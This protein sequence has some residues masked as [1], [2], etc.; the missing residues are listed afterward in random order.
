MDDTLARLKKESR[1]IIIF[2]AGVTGEAV[3]NVCTE[4]GIPVAAFCDNNRDKTTCK[5]SDKEILYAPS[6]KERYPDAVF[7]IAVIDIQ[8]IVKQLHGLGFDVYYPVS[9]L[10]R[11]YDVFRYEYS[12]PADF[13]EYVVSA[14]IHSHD[15]FAHPDK[16]FIRSVDLVI[17]ERCSL[18]CRDCSNLMQYYQ[19]PVNYPLPVLLQ[20]IDSL[21]SLVDEINEFRVIGGEPFMNPE[22]PLITQHVYKK[23]TVHRVIFYTNGTILPKEEYFPL[24]QNP[25]TMFIITDYGP[26]SRNIDKLCGKLDEYKIMYSRLPVGGWTDCAKIYDRKRSKSEL[27]EIFDCCCVKNS[28]TLSNGVLYRCP[29]AANADQLAKFTSPPGD[30][31]LLNGASK[32][33]LQRFI[34]KT[35]FIQACSFCSG[36]RL[37]DP[38]ITPAIQLTGPLS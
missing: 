30:H 9:D 3:L 10:L 32:I 24:L 37:D 34:R 16:L 6:L 18:K 28:F 12:K 36:R 35:D 17:T 8:D 14:C 25:K 26:L 31:I 7:I 13:V 27:Q 19:K 22:W 38:K 20:S 2:G 11:Y 29:F 5:L 33:D 1:P 23:A 21:C 4:N 15:S